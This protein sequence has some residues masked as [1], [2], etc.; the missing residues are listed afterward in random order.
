MK[1]RSSLLFRLSFAWLITA[2]LF[3]HSVTETFARG[4]I[5]GDLP[6]S[7]L[8]GSVTSVIDVSHRGAVDYA[9]DHS[10]GDA[11]LVAT[12]VATL[13]R[14]T[15]TSNY[16]PP[17][18]DPSG[19][20]YM[21]NSNTLLISDGE[22]EEMPQYFTG[23]NVFETTLSGDLVATY[24]TMD[25]SN[26]PT[27]VGFN[28]NNGHLFFSDDIRGRVFEVDLG[29]DGLLGTSDDIVT[30]FSTN[31]FSAVD[32]EGVAFDSWRGHLF[33]VD[34]VSE[35]VFDVDP[36]NNGLFDGIAPDGDDSVTQFSTTG[37][38]IDDPEGLAFNH[39]NGH[40]YILSSPSD[41]MAETT[42][43]GTLVNHIDL[44][45]IG[46]LAGA[47]L[48]YAPA[49]D[50]PGEMHIYIVDRAVDNG[51]DP[52]ENDGMLFEITFPGL[53]PAANQAPY[54][55]A[56]PDQWVALMEDALLDGTVSDDGLP[57]PPAQL[58]VAWSRIS[59]PGSVV[60]S[61]PSSVDTTANFSV[62]GQY[63]LEL[64]ADD[65]ELTR[66]DTL[67]VTVDEPGT[68]TH[69]FDTR[70]A[71][72]AD[73]AE[74]SASGTIT[75]GSSDLEMVYDG[76]N[77][78]VG[79]RFSGVS[80]PQGARIAE[81]VVQFRADES[82]TIATT[83]MIAGQAADSAG[84]FTTAAGNISGRPRTGA[85]IPWNPVQWLSVGDTGAA[86]RTPDL[87][88]VIQ[89]IVDRPGWSSGNALAL[90]I[91]G[92][93]ERVAE[94]Y[95]G[96]PAGAPLLHVV[97]VL[98]PASNTPPDVDAGPDSTVILP[99][100]AVLNGTVIDDG[101][102]DPPGVVT[103]TWSRAGGPGGVTF[104]DASAVDTTANFAIPGEYVLRLTATDG[105][106]AASDDVLVSVRVPGTEA[107]VFEGRVV[108]GSDDAE[109]SAAGT[110][111]LASS[112]LE[113]VYDGSNQS[114]GIRFVGVDIP[115]GVQVQDAY[116][117]FQAEE[118]SSGATNLRIE[119]QAAD[120]ANAFT[121]QIGNISQRVRTTSFVMWNP[122]PWLT[123]GA[124]GPAERTP[125][126][127][128]VIQE[129][130]D[131]PGWVSGNPLAL[132]VTGSGERVAESYDGFAAGAP[133]LHVEYLISPSND[134]PTVDAGPDQ[135]ITLPDEALLDGTVTDDGLPNPPGALTLAWSRVSGP[136]TVVFGDATVADTTASFSV[137][138]WR[139]DGQRQP[140]RDGGAGG[141]DEYSP[142]GRR[143][144]GPDDHAA[145]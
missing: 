128:A 18:P 75:L 20:S 78:T 132:I 10:P 6:A 116:V 127:S 56:G 87:S 83:L 85:A 143:R 110:V 84:Q 97:Y 136:G 52:N 120:F 22:V 59:G 60:F 76:S 16:D 141:A 106:L 55:N 45:N 100:S 134:P 9:D 129:I 125:D 42:V 131:R 15:A 103:V 112:D 94:S 101:L 114:V 77:Q 5:A 12:Y 95:D 64:S 3:L 124:A 126:I 142:A 33:V 62:A 119:G 89:E 113:M 139:P 93:G 2:G 108:S 105:E 17:S 63:V 122:T 11:P 51:S 65:G 86:Q 39:N 19:L 61:D 144:A 130:V 23:D 118:S 49:S 32:P 8:V 70:I 138:G 91:T 4:E 117:Q 107:E 34:G 74:E 121:G 66:S 37:L 46:I 50:N 67:V 68:E 38:G 102:P 140:D 98:G 72:G 29:A 69:I 31:R 88:Q 25:F 21:P 79:L 123:I 73:D 1:I 26:E 7:R 133:L 104:G 30:D 99:N 35:R 109:E 47:G 71:T 111:S 58:T 115:Q 53:G 28:P 92:S 41:L 48:A 40:L 90:I 24:S 14:A 96:M 54:V 145:G 80:I 27:G 13:V 36:G 135:T 57:D 81:A 44:S 43:D 137:A 82:G